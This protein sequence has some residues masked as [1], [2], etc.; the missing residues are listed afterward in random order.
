MWNSRQACAT[1]QARLRSGRAQAGVRSGPESEL[2]ESRPR[3]LEKM[4][5]THAGQQPGQ[6]KKKVSRQETKN[7]KNGAQH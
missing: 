2:Y 3:I 4:S 7:T 6:K 5:R 1:R